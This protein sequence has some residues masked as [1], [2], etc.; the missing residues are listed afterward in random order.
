M[1]PLKLH[2][3]PAIQKPYPRISPPLDCPR[4]IPAI[5][6]PEFP[7]GQI[8]NNHQNRL[9]KPVESPDLLASDDFRVQT[10]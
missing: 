7:A 6:V 3:T 4:G 9:V 10:S 2:E 1:E 8:Q 5:H